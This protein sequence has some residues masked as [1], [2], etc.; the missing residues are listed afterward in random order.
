MDE[1]GIDVGARLKIMKES[2]GERM[3][4]GIG[5]VDVFMA[6]GRL[7]RKANKGFC[8]YEKGKSKLVKGQKVVDPKVFTGPIRN[9]DRR[10]TQNCR[11]I[12]VG[13]GERSRMV[14]P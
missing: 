9:Q 11:T 14:S 8:V 12:G 2:Y 7:G 6:E 3:N 1:V 4:P 13:F 5:L 10:P